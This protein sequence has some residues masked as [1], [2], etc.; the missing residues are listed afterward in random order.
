MT[1]EIDRTVEL[2][3][4]GMTCGHCVMSVTEELEEIAGVK[5]VEVILNSGGTS[6]VTVVTD[7]ELDD[8]ALRDAVAEAGFE[9]VGITRDF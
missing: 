8:D 7:S 5:N 6:K 3:V 1:I 4:D 2:S 9:L